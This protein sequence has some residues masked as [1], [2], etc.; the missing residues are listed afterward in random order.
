MGVGVAVLLAC[1]VAAGPLGWAAIGMI[2][3]GVAVAGTAGV[4]FG[5]ASH[6]LSK[7]ADKLD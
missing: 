4:I 3:T 2:Y 5:V 7:D 6:N 1:H